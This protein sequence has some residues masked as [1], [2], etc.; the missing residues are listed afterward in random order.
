MNCPDRPLKVETR[1]RTR[2]DC[3]AFWLVRGVM[4]A[5]V[6]ASSGNFVRRSSVRFSPTGSA[7]IVGTVRAGCCG[8]SAFRIAAPVPRIYPADHGRTRTRRGA[9]QPGS[10][11]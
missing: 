11:G 10:A 9:V 7:V 4:V 3:V 8:A 6:P 5:S 1:V 2:W